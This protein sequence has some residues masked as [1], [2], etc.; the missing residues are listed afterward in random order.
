MDVVN[1]G[2]DLANNVCAGHGVGA[3]G[4]PMLVLPVV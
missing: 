3:T 1:A 2:I 4:K